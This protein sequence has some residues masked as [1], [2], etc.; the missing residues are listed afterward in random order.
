[1]GAT[2]RHRNQWRAV[3]RLRGL[4][5][6]C[7]A[8]YIGHLNVDYYRDIEHGRRLSS[9][10]LL[11]RLLCLMNCSLLQAYPWLVWEAEEFVKTRLRSSPT[12]KSPPSMGQKTRRRSMTTAH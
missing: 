6:R 1:M 11:A 9:I 7:V 8:S 10:P 3:R 4:T 2:R 5:Q 12:K